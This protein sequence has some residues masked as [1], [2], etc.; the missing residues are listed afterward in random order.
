MALV[1][2][3]VDVSVVDGLEEVEGLSVA[4][5]GVECEVVPGVDSISEPLEA[6]RGGRHEVWRDCSDFRDAID[7]VVCSCKRASEGVVVEVVEPEEAG[8][9]GGVEDLD[10]VGRHLITNEVEGEVDVLQEE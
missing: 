10:S 7:S 5:E 8:D 2:G 3:E 9:S 1:G 6:A 4:F